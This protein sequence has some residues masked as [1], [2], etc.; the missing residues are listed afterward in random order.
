[1]PDDTIP[2]EEATKVLCPRCEAEDDTCS[3][4]H[5]AGFV[6]HEARAAYVQEM[7]DRVRGIV[8]LPDTIP[9]PPPDD[10]A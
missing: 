5:G 10:A 3:M 8:G 7:S 1:M 4:C 2:D 6:T 9:C